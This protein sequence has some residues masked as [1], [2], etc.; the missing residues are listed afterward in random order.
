V[1]FA[2][3]TSNAAAV[4]QAVAP[5]RYYHSAMD[6]FIVITDLLTYLVTTSAFAVDAEDIE[7]KSSTSASLPRLSAI[8]DPRLQA[9]W[10]KASPKPGYYCAIA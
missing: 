9:D 7:S 3:V 10:D 5:A 1:G 2:I 4:V 6:S 8:D